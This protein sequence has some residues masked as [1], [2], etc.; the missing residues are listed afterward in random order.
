VNLLFGV[1]VTAALV[2]LMRG[3]NVAAAILIAAAI[4]VKPYAVLFVPWLAWVRPRVLV[5]LVA[6]GVFVA[7]LPAA[8]YGWA[9]NIDLHWDWWRT[10]TESTAPN[11]TNPDNVSLAA[12]FAKW[13]GITAAAARLAAATGVLLL[14]VT[15]LV[16]LHGRDLPR[17]EALEGALLLTLIPLLSPQ[18]WDYVFLI[19]TPAVVLFANH[20]ARLP[21]W[22]RGLTWIAVATIGLSLFDVLGRARYATF[23][24]WSVIT[25]CF[26]VLIGALVAL[27]LRRIA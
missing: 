21:S 1:L 23:M 4:V 10:V 15:A 20:E 7:F 25:V 6:A 27:R 2:L 26:C 3:A 5:P 17:R 16:V 13:M 19:A 14:I 9:G 22:M 24:A 11:L 12:F 8:A 18:G